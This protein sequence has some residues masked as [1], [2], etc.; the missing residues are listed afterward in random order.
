ML[1]LIRDGF[2]VCKSMG[3]KPMFGMQIPLVW[4]CALLSGVYFH[5]IR[6]GEISHAHNKP[7]GSAAAEEGGH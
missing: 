1:T 4:T 3:L 7:Q 6:R 5:N 2:N